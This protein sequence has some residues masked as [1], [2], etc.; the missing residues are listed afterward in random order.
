MTHQRET[1]KSIFGTALEIHSDDER[2]RYL[3][4]A[5]RGNESLRAEV[6]DLLSAIV[7]AGQFLGGS[8]PGGMSIDQPR[9]ERLPSQIGPYKLLEEIGEGGFGLVFMAEQHQPVH[10]KVAIK[11]IKPGMDT[12]QIIARFGAERQALAMMDHPNIA[13]VFDAGTTES[14]RPYFVMELVR[15]I[16]ITEYC[17]QCNLPP[18]ERLELAI[19]VCQAV[20]HAH[21]KGV[22]HRDIKPSNVLV[23]LPDGKP[24]AKMI[25]FGVAKAINQRLTEESLRTAF[26][27]IIGTPLYMS[28]EQAEMSS[29]DVDTRSDIY[30]LGVL[31]YELLT[32]MTPFEKSRLKKAAFDEL[33]RIIREEE[34]PRP[35]YRLSTLQDNLLSTVS[36]HRRIDPKKLRQLV[37][38]DLDWIVMKCLEKDRTRRYDTASALAAD[39]RRYLVDQPIEARAPS[40]AYRFRKFA[41]RHKVVLTAAALVMT[42]VMAGVV[43]S[44]GQAVR[45]THAERAAQAQAERARQKAN[46]AEAQRQQ[47]VNHLE[48][49]ERQRERAEDAEVQGRHRLVRLTVANGMRH[50]DSGELMSSLPWFTEALRL[51][52]ADSS[53]TRLHRIRIG[54][55]LRQCPKLACM[56]FHE[57]P[58][59]FETGTFHLKLAYNAEFSPD[60]RYVVAPSGNRAARVWDTRNG[61]VVHVL[62]HD[63]TALHAS[64]SR[65]GRM[66]ATACG[67]LG[68]GHG[69]FA[70]VWHADTGERITRF[71]HD[72]AVVRALFSP[73]GDRLFT[74][75]LDGTARVWDV[76]TGEPL[77]PIMQHNVDVGDVS[78]FAFS[79]DGRRVI[80]AGQNA[81]ALI[82]DL[83]TGQPSHRSIE[84]KRHASFSP[85]GNL[86]VTGGGVTRVWDVSTGSLTCELP[87]QSWHASFSPAGQQIVTASSDETAQIW[88]IPSGR[89]VGAPMRHRSGVTQARFSPDGRYVVTASWDR[90]AR[91]WDAGTGRPITL[92]LKHG[93][94]VMC[95]AFHPDG[96]RIVTAS[97]DLL[98]RVWDFANLQSGSRTIHHTNGESNQLLLA[99]L[100]PDGR[101]LATAGQ[102]RRLRLRESSS[103]TAMGP[104]IERVGVL[105]H[106]DFSSDSKRV[107]TTNAGGTARIWDSATG[108]PIGAPLRHANGVMHGSFSPDGDRVVTASSDCS[109]RVWELLT[110]RTIVKFEHPSPVKYAWFSPDG[111]C[112]LSVCDAEARVWDAATGEPISP[113]LHHR[114]AIVY[115]CF[116]PDGLRVLTTSSDGT[117]QVWDATTG[118]PIGEPLYHGQAVTHG[119]FSPDARKVVTASNDNTARVWD[120]VRGT[121]MTLGWQP[122]N[123]W[124]AAFSRDGQLI[125]T[126]CLDG[127]VRVWDANTGEPVTGALR[128]SSQWAIGAEFSPDGRR[129]LTTGR[130]AAKLWDL[131][132]DRRPIEDLELLA[133]V[134]CGHRIDETGG[135][136]DPVDPGELRNAWQNLRDKYPSEF[137]VSPND[138][139]AWHREEADA[140][141]RIGQWNDAIRHLTAAQ[142]YDLD[143]SHASDY[144][145]TLERLKKRRAEDEEIED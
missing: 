89:R 23:A 41:R 25:D 74:G 54:T 30:S 32:G 99:R 31:L 45:A 60:G 22:I 61:R 94:D 12:K 103:Q 83:E 69:G 135:R 62:S 65:D 37:R 64:F 34:P 9:A 40:T 88:D 29:L 36:Q 85:D 125:A 118:E 35:S 49:A 140:C 70:T 113:S 2:A 57:G 121:S 137:V 10:R 92:P 90:T 116:S 127:M 24:V 1:V 87:Q 133:Q 105:H 107:L 117:A 80:T 142:Q 71:A 129:L 93:G 52:H 143:S 5:C 102:D 75:S 53:R 130:G 78:V 43:V 42:S 132:P 72:A 47:A 68:G 95:A 17:D 109:A 20:Q 122:N 106:V 81:V 58:V 138:L 39:L 11:I 124:H 63:L 112:V 56:W 15:G 48:L 67:D 131:R 111:C 100:S 128:H 79:P 51:D 144:Q 98:V 46:E 110:G 8:S 126:A 119:V 139:F 38:G 59:T 13:K 6:N 96:H 101:L 7:R 76:H 19:S 27:E 97:T 4:Q 3:D 91:L 26:A 114:S 82:W 141:A 33:R 104:V 44:T 18:R 14:G 21:Q 28:P 55:T 108:D 115:A 134:L 66:I 136:L 77:T 123:V 84:G 73:D 50:L 86:A 16:P 120:I 145:A